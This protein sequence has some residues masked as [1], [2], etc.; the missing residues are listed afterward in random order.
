MQIRRAQIEVAVFCMGMLV[1]TVVFVPMVMVVLASL[2][3]PGAQQ[4]HNQPQCRD[5]NG[6]FIVDG[7][8]GQQAFHGL[9]GHQR[10]DQQ[11]Q[12]GAGVSRQNFDLPCAEGKALVAGQAPRCGIRSHGK[13]QRQGVGAHVPAIG[14]Q[15]HGVEVIAPGNLQGHHGQG[16]QH[17][18]LGF[19]FRQGVACI[20]D[21]GVC[22]QPAGLRGGA[23]MRRSFIYC[24]PVY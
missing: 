23:S 8:G 15:G 20:K 5:T 18:Q 7:G 14:Q 3:Q 21:V 9:D 11:Q 6:L 19:L 12:D 13:S 24:T 1:V 4:I 16:Q 2:E 10:C 17:R 22:G